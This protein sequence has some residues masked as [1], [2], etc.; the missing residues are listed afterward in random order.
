MTRKKVWIRLPKFEDQI[1]AAQ[2]G[3]TKRYMIFDDI[4]EK[5]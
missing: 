1:K 5:L 4:K 2:K 3:T